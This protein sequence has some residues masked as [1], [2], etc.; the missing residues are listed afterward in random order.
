MPV[1]TLKWRGGLDGCLRIIDQRALPAELKFLDLQSAREVFDAI[2][3]MAV[4]GAP[5]IGIAAGYGAFLGVRGAAGGPP[6]LRE[7]LH[8]TCGFLRSSRP[9][10]ANLFHALDRVWGGDR[11]RRLLRRAGTRQEGL[12]LCLRD[13]SPPAGRQTDRM[14]AHARGH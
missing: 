5:A 6:E 14:G 10:G 8:R 2:R 11:A 3:T 12:R 7:G 9:T 4:R 1:E 13:P